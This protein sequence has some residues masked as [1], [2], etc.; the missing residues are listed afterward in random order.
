MFINHHLNLEA[1]LEDLI[2]SQLRDPDRVDFDRMQS[3]AKVELTR[4]LAG[5]QT[6]DYLWEIVLKF[7]ETRN[8]IA[9]RK[10][11]LPPQKFTE[12]RGLVTKA[13]SSALVAD[14]TQVMMS[15]LKICTWFL[16]E[17]KQ[18]LPPPLP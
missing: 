4:A 12:L 15:A 9:H 16:Q 5:P 6:D 8:T 7:N 13:V 11:T 14:D 2:R 3:P 18:S 17:I 10:K 1:Q